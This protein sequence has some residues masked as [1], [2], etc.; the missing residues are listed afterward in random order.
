MFAATGNLVLG[1]H[2]ERI[3]GI[4][5]DPSLAPGEYRPLTASEVR[6]IA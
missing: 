6:S 3:G 2:R 4:A 5:L 1:L